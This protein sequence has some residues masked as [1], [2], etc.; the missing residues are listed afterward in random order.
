M[1]IFNI[2][3]VVVYLAL[4][5]FFSKIFI[6]S[7]RMLP[8]LFGIPVKTVVTNDNVTSFIDFYNL[9][10]WFEIW[11]P[12]FVPLSII[13]ITF[14]MYR[15]VI[16]NGSG[17]IPL[18]IMIITIVINVFGS[19]ML[20]KG[21]WANRSNIVVT[22]NYSAIRI[23]TDRTNKTA[24]TTNFNVVALSLVY[25]MVSYTFFYFGTIY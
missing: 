1:M 22:L 11:R 20:Q 7:P 24:L 4:F 16:V 14:T 13:A 2:I 25:Y 5:I 21:I 8:L 10:H 17:D 6:A 15:P 9:N 18:F 12:I 3:S 23:I 19:M